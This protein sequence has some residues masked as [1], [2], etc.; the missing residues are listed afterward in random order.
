MIYLGYALWQIIKLME[1]LIMA[2]KKKV[3]ILAEQFF[4]KDGN[5]MLRGGA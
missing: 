4:T 3:A 1:R 2:K 5:N